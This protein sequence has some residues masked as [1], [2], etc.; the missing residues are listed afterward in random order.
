LVGL[1]VETASAKTRLEKIIKQSSS[2]VAQALAG[3]SLGSHVLAGDSLGSER[4]VVIIKITN[5]NNNVEAQ[6]YTYLNFIEFSKIFDPELVQS[7]LSLITKYDPTKEV[8]IFGFAKYDD[9]TKS[10]TGKPLFNLTS[11]TATM[12]RDIVLAAKTIV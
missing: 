10:E 7:V 9:P 6:F 5:R 8:L 11:V 3:D 1:Q 12:S 4:G 2:L